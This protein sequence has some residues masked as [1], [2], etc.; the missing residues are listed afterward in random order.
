MQTSSIHQRLQ[1]L[2]KAFSSVPELGIS[3]PRDLEKWVQEE[4]GSLDVLS[5]FQKR[6]SRWV[7]AVA[8]ERLLI[9]GAGNLVISL[10]QSILVGLI[11]GSSLWVKPGSG[12]EKDLGLFLQKIPRKL[13]QK[14]EVLKRVP[15]ELIP[16]ADA[17]VV[18]GS[19][20]SIQEIQKQSHPKQRFIAYGHRTSAM[21]IGKLPP[22][23]KLFDQV[24]QDICIYEQQGCLSP[25]WIWLSPQVDET[26]FSKKLGEALNRWVTLH[27]KLLR[28]NR[29][30]PSQEA[31]IYELRQTHIAIGNQVIA[32]SKNLD[33]TIVHDRKGMAEH[34]TLPRVIVIRSLSE[35]RIA[36]EFA[37]MSG[38]LS[39][40]G[41]YS[42]MSHF[43]EQ[44]FI[45]WGAS[46]FCPLGVMQHPPLNW[47][48]DG[49]PSISD[50]VR[51]VEKSK[52]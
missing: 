49:R 14:I 26:I 42:E 45:R 34:T 5:S 37:W 46:R 30:S 25:R 11:L 7:Q 35:K 16:L 12:T 48:H 3:S 13:R 41:V 36:Q 20:E 1:I 4:L 24:A 19:D 29:L 28:T 52:L 40:V 15:A 33:W 6:G 17:V 43:L 22:T 27:A 9:V 39:T 31:L 38:D 18:L 51:W 23:E 21:W 2:G 8:P 32:S 10:W 44:T 47:L 50:L